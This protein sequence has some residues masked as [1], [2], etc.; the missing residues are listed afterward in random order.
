MNESL[1]GLRILLAEDETILSLLIE[2][3]LV[4]AGAT[5][6]GPAPSVGTALD[7]LRDEPAVDGA[8]LDYNLG[9]EMIEP[10]ADALTAQRIPFVIVTGYGENRVNGSY[11]HATVLAK[12]IDMESFA[13][14]VYRSLKG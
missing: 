2:D 3:L 8:V 5:V 7:L 10:V 6:I 12:P 13:G 14:T 4:E 11:P 1:A 9:G